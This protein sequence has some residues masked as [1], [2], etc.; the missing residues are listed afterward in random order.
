MP[1]GA[2]DSPAGGDGGLQAALINCLGVYSYSMLIIGAIVLFY[3]LTAMVVE[4]AHH[5]VVMGRRANQVWAP[6][7]LV[8]AVGLM[9]PYNTGLNSGQYIILEVAAWGSN[10]ASN[11]WAVF[12]STLATGGTIAPAT[13]PFS[14]G[15]VGDTYLTAGCM[16][17]WNQM[18]TAT[19]GANAPLINGPTALNNTDGSVK[20]SFT[21]VAGGTIGVPAYDKDLCGFYVTP[22]NVQAGSGVEND[23]AGTVSGGVSGAYAQL[24]NDACTDVGCANAPAGNVAASALGDIFYFIDESWVISAI[25]LLLLN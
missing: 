14:R 21:P 22:S 24:L 25:G 3:H 19:W 20:Y 17:A 1:V 2:A 8:I 13:A 7:R 18:A 15:V 11:I 12:V 5:G 10:L 16:T 9:V 23:I 4:T 6:I